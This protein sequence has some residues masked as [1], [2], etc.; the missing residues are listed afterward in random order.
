MQDDIDL[1]DDSQKIYFKTKFE[2]DGWFRQP[3]SDDDESSQ[4]RRF[5]I[6]TEWPWTA[7]MSHDDDRSA[8]A[9]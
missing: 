1:L 6:Y 2:L 7:V 8:I 3:D 5:R 9:N 4:K